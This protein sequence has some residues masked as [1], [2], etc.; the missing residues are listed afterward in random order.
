MR[1]GAHGQTIWARGRA[2]ARSVAHVVGCMHSSCKR[3]PPRASQQCMVI[4][5]AQLH[6]VK[7]SP[8]CKHNLIMRLFTKGMPS[9]ILNFEREMLK[10]MPSA[11]RMCPQQCRCW[12]AA[13]YW[14]T[15]SS[16]TTSPCPWASL[17][18]PSRLLMGIP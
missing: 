15:Q 1:E 2:H 3:G 16:V 8:A 9:Q 12:Y 11:L 17:D 18:F 5:R 13:V 6:C 4:A 14:H 7:A 10:G